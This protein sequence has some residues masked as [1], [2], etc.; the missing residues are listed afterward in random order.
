MKYRTEIEEYLVDTICDDVDDM[1]DFVDARYDLEEDV[2]IEIS[3]LTDDELIATYGDYI[4]HISMDELI[5][6]IES[7]ED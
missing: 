3:R 2:V 1:I 6:E 4:T 7:E 5:S